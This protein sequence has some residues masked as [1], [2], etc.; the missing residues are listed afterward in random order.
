MRKLLLAAFVL[1]YLLGVAGNQAF[2]AS[3]GNPGEAEKGFV[4]LFNGRDLTGWEGDASLWN[5][6]NGILVGRSPGLAHNDFLATTRSYKDF[7]LKLSFRLV[8]DA[9]NSGVQFRSKP[10]PNS[11]EVS[12]YQAEIAGLMT[13]SLYDESRRNRFLVDASPAGSE[14]VIK[15]GGWN[16]YVVR[17]QG[18]HIVLELNGLKTADYRESDLSVSRSGIIALQIH[19]GKPME[20]QFKNIRIKVLR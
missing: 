13:G 12:G 18:N 4:S 7:I 3:P 17:C 2:S 5:V 19:G 9:G 8:N 10:V 16:D 14:K 15:K 20:V 11:R 1:P 6:E